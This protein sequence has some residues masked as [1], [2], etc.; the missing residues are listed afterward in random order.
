MPCESLGLGLLLVVI[1]V[2]E[3]KNS[4]ENKQAVNTQTQVAYGAWWWG[5]LHKDAWMKLWQRQEARLLVF[6]LTLLSLSSNKGR[7]VWRRKERQGWRDFCFKDWERTYW[8]WVSSSSAPSSSSSSSSP[9]C[10]TWPLGEEVTIGGGMGR[11]ENVGVQ[12]ESRN[13]ELR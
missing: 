2:I 10:A 8:V 12:E 1:K 3:N 13:W 4:L 9:K 7:S 5:V 6:F 11:E